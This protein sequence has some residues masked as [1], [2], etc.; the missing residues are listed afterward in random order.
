[1]KDVEAWLEDKIIEL[2]RALGGRLQE[3]SLH[4]RFNPSVGTI[5]M[6]DLASITVDTVGW[7]QLSAHKRQNRLHKVIQRMV[8]EHKIEVR[9]ESGEPT[10]SE[11]YTRYIYELSVLDRIAAHLGDDDGPQI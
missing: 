7:T 1:M 10:F 11:D 3:H 5:W 8:R 4:S 2:V 9:N 6:R